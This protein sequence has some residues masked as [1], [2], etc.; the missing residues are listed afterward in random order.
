MDIYLEHKYND[1]SIDELYNIFDKNI[2]KL[3]YF[4][5]GY[6]ISKF[7]WNKLDLLDYISKKKKYIY[8]ID[9]NWIETHISMYKTIDKSDNSKGIVCEII[10]WEK[11]QKDIMFFSEWKI[12]NIVEN[13]WG[14]ILS[15]WIIE[16]KENINKILYFLN[17]ELIFLESK[18]HRYQSKLRYNW[19]LNKE[20]SENKI[21]TFKQ[22]FYKTILNNS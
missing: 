8:Y 12:Y 11:K 6:K 9:K 18:I 1:F 4:N 3:S 20:T 13:K 15:S 10:I 16:N 19:F 14:K 7:F 22:N 17:T 21:N 5:F 2:T